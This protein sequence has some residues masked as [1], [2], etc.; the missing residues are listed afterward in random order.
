MYV[1][2]VSVVYVEID[3]LSVETDFVSLEV[4][5]V[6]KYKQQIITFLF[7]LLLNQL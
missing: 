5:S 3:S 4:E 2:R 1:F 7:P 6:K